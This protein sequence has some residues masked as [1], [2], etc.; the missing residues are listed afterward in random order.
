MN[1][2]AHFYEKGIAIVTMHLIT[3]RKVSC[4]YK[5]VSR[6]RENVSLL[7]EKHRFITRKHLVIM[8]YVSHCY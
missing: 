5:T 8:S 7:Q 3:T 2:A 4:Y 1:K 6:Y